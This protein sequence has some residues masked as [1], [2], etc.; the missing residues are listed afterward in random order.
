MNRTQRGMSLIELMI[1]M[2]LGLMVMG[3]A[4]TAF[5][6]VTQVA[7]TQ[8]GMANISD[9]AQ[10]ADVYLGKQLVQAGYL[11]LLATADNRTYLTQ[12]DGSGG[13]PTAGSG[14]LLSSAYSLTHAGLYSLHGCNGAYSSNTALLNYTCSGTSNNTV[15]SVSVA[16]QVLATPNGWLAPSVA[17]APS[18]TQG[19]QTD[20]G[21]LSPR[22]AVNPLANP[23][24]DVVINRF[25]L[26]TATR[27]LM[28]VGNGNPN[29]P[30][31]IASNVEQFVV[32]YGL[33]QTSLTGSESVANYVTAAAVDAL[34][35]SAWGSV[36]SVQF[37]LLVRGDPGSAN[38]TN[39]ANNVFNLD[40]AGQPA[41][42]NDGALRRAHRV[43]LSVRNAV[44]SAVALP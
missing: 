25:Y 15:N 14:D 29:A 13:A 37:C 36:L 21:T 12:L 22:A 24:G 17:D 20:C 41:I 7:R 30:V 4:L 27:Q 9:G 8:R 1:G 39:T 10:A 2:T 40:C 31:R 16:Y 6:G 32:R 18:A 26:D 3:V 19:Y 33:P 34:G 23:P 35:P 44:R 42:A 11:D 5:F 28:C 43:T 38:L